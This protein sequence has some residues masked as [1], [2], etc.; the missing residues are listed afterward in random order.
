MARAKPPAIQVLMLSSTI[1]CLFPDDSQFI[2]NILQPVSG[3]LNHWTPQG[4]FVTAHAA[5][6]RETCSHASKARATSP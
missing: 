1:G 4:V 3:R 2:S 5:K 6:E